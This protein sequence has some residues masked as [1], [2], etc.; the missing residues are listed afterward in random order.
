[1]FDWLNP[2]NSLSTISLSQRLLGNASKVDF[3]V[4][5]LERERNRVLIE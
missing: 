3:N 5:K 4:P 1:M 2:Q